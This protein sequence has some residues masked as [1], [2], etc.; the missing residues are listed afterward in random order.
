MKSVPQRLRRLDPL[1]MLALVV[2]I[3]AVVSTTAQA[4]E[5]T[6]GEHSQL[7]VSYQGALPALRKRLD[8]VAQQADGLLRG[9]LP[10]SG[11]ARSLR[12]SLSAPEIT[13]AVASLEKPGG[14]VVEEDAAMTL[15]FRRDW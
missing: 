15:I 12:L 3:G 14:F 5:R 10:A 6:S 13:P 9:V 1:L 2:G 11:D 7:M 8:R 4:Q